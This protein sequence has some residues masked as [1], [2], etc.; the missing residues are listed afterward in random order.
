MAPGS[1]RVWP[2]GCPRCQPC[3]VRG[4]GFREL[5]ERSSIQELDR[6]APELDHASLAKFVEGQ[7][8][9]F[10][11]RTDHVGQLLVAS[12]DRPVSGGVGHAQQYSRKPRGHAFEGEILNDGFFLQQPRTELFQ[13]NASPLSD[14]AGS[15]ARD[16]CG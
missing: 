8:G 10:A 1:V 9:R 6:A 12:A 14:A 15:D 5:F 4:S 3:L 7:R 16:P 2:R 13:G 11:V